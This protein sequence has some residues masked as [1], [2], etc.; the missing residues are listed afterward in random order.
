MLYEKKKLMVRRL[1]WLGIMLLCILIPVIVS[2][3]Q[4]KP[5]EIVD[6]NC[7]LIEYF[8]HS[9]TTE[10]EVEVVFDKEVYSG[11]ITV[12]F[13]DKYDKLLT[14]KK[15]YFYGYSNTLSSTFFIDGKVDS[16]EIL[17]Y[18]ISSYNSGNSLTAVACLCVG[19]I[20]FAFLITS[21]TLSC[22]VYD[23]NGNEII[24]YCGF[25]HHYIKINGEILDEHNTIMSF[26]PIILSCDI[27]EGD[28]VTATMTLLN[29]I[30]LKINNRLY[31][32]KKIK[33]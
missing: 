32:P 15:E 28:V 8:E 13:Y 19:I 33:G 10:C 9:D 5:L 1:V 20:S 23:Y 11:Y 30:S 12:A 22:K 24:A 16:Y 14:Q 31:K 2:N 27:D 17:S 21:L 6:D 3:V 4:S 26:T 7:Y 29:R 18:D 25:Y